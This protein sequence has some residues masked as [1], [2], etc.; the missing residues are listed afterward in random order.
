MCLF[1]N[2]RITRSIYVYMASG[3]FDL[4]SKLIIYIR[5]IYIRNNIT[6]FIIMFI[7]TIML[8]IIY[9]L[10]FMDIFLEYQYSTSGF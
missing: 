1:S 2:Q 6:M 3:T 7:I 10:L 8:H 9:T 5:N 4:Y